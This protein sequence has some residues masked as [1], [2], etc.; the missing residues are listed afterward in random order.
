MNTKI[1][2]HWVSG[3]C[4]TTTIKLELNSDKTFNMV[5]KSHWMGGDDWT[6]NLRG[7]TKNVKVISKNNVKKSYAL[8]EPIEIEGKKR[9]GADYEAPDKSIDKNVRIRVYFLAEPKLTKLES[10]EDEWIGWS[11]SWNK[12]NDATISAKSIDKTNKCLTCLCESIHKCELTLDTI[13]D[14]YNYSPRNGIDFKSQD[15]NCYANYKE[16]ASVSI[17]FN[18]FCGVSNNIIQ[19]IFEK[20]ILDDILPEKI[21]IDGSG[22]ISLIPFKCPKPFPLVP[23]VAMSDSPT[24]DFTRSQHSTPYH[25]MQV[26]KIDTIDSLEEHKKNFDDITKRSTLLMKDEF[27]RESAL[28]D[29]DT[30]DVDNTYLFLTK[31]TMDY[32]VMYVDSMDIIC[33]IPKKGDNQMKIAEFDFGKVSYKLIK[34]KKGKLLTLLSNSLKK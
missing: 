29:V 26:I 10:G 14:K 3:G 18:T 15:L 20:L 8:L 12:I 30:H 22:D 5:A 13:D 32:G 23:I 19:F 2:T 16:L 28:L 6:W 24:N 34:D 27:Y 9:I 33:Q 25:I 4:G 7:T 11:G 31:S 17:V 21:Y 1:Y